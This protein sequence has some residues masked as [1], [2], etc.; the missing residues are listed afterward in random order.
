MSRDK[1]AG[2]TVCETFGGPIS[3]ETR[4]DGLNSVF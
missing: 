1:L 3:R 4:G 2:G